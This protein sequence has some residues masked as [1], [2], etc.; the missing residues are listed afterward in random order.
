M[1]RCLQ[2]M[3]LVGEDISHP[4]FA[5]IEEYLGR[6]T[7]SYYDVLADV[8]QGAWRPENGA[9]PWVRFCL[10]AHLRQADYTAAI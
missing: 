8:G 3:A 7:Q 10:L 1:A 5:S 2:T 9:V 4:V 6:S